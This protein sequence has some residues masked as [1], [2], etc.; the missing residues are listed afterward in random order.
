[1]GFA[2]ATDA[3]FMAPLA[4]TFFDDVREVLDAGDVYLGLRIV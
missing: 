3:A 2:R 4:Q 1:M